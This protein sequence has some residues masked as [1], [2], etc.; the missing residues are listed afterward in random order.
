MRVAQIDDQI[1]CLREDA[2][3]HIP[4]WRILAAQGKV[5]CPKCRD[6]LSLV[7]GISDEPRFI[8]HQRSH[9]NCQAELVEEESLDRSYGTPADQSLSQ[10]ET[11]AA[12]ETEDAPL[13]AENDAISVRSRFQLPKN[14]VIHTEPAVSAT[15]DRADQA[16]RFRRRLSP[17]TGVVALTNKLDDTFHPQQRQAITTTEGP[18]LILAGA[19]SGKT[20]VMTARTA[21]LIQHKGID[22]RSIMVVTFT[23]KAADEIRRRLAEK[24]SVQ[25]AKALVAGT[26]H[27]L[28][29]RMLLHHDPRSWDQRRLL[30]QDWQKARLLRESGLLSSSDTIMS[31]AEVLA[32]L[33]VISRWKNE[34]ILPDSLGSLSPVSDEEARAR[35]LYPLYAQ[36]KQRS[37]WFDFDDML[38]GCYHLLRDH[39]AIRNQYQQRIAYIMIDEFQDI[40][41]VQYETVKL[42]A[43]PQNNLCV[44]G[45]DD[46]SIY[47]FRGSDPQY[48]LGF[49]RDYPEAKTITLEVNYR[50]RSLIVSLGYSLIGNNRTRW[51]KELQG[52]HQEEGNC[53]LFQ[54]EDEEEQ[55]ARI[56]DEISSLAQKG[57]PLEEI[58]IL[59]RTYDSSRPLL[60]RLMQAEIPVSFIREGEP[61]YQRQAVR[62]ALG[63]L[64]LALDHDD[65]DALREILQTLYIS[66]DQWNLIRSQA[67]LHDTSLLDVLPTLQHLKPY[68]RKQLE[69]VVSVLHQLPALSPKQALELVYEDLKLREYVKK[70]AKDRAAGE[71]ARAVDE[72]RQLLSAAKRHATLGAFLRHLEQMAKWEKELPASYGNSAQVQAVQLI[73][74]HRAK[75]LE[76]DNVFL[77]D[78]V[79]GVLPHEYAIDQLR[80]GNP[81]ALEE[82]R[83]L[84]YVAITRARHN[85]YLGVPHERFGRQTKVSRFVREMEQTPPSSEP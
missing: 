77:L 31:E 25:Q 62:W 53:I 22:P 67:I 70:R 64:R 68:Q 65:Q 48:I 7:A 32:A 1:I 66:A 35:D 11:A 13:L 19:G 59:F 46:Q 30:K 12:A 54:P 3:Q 50:S 58:A 27:G 16:K 84:L 56:V 39:P 15:A 43:S 23:T 55:A 76:F 6:R 51:K 57:V 29:Y 4:E 41:R 20:R 80:S 14:R 52:Y 10:T 73:S 75:G 60:E 78:L 69:R 5:I 2:Y 63:Y 17:R 33:A 38:L 79:E 26:F 44:I 81:D 49:T 28:F 21:H 83:R 40:N 72:L 9:A 37:G 36:A 74:I 24:L 47:G 42:L 34:C 8:H 82:E 61:F 18:L 71:D 85:L 45:D